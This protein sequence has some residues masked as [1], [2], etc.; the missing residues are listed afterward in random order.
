MKGKWL[1]WARRTHLFLSVFFSP[2]LVLFIV[3]GCWQTFTTDEERQADGG[4]AHTLMVKLSS[5]HTDD[6][7]PRANEGHHSPVA[8]KFFVLSMALALLA[9]IALGLA[10]AWQIKRKGLVLAALIL[11]VIVPAALLFLF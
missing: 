1:L 9:S 7:F 3:T 11:G 8:F 2:L 4:V 5:I 10:L 6:E